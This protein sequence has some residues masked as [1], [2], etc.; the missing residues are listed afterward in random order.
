MRSCAPVEPGEVFGHESHGGGYGYSGMG[1]HRGG[2]AELVRVPYADYNCP[3][4]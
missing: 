3:S 4:V 2:Q 1:P